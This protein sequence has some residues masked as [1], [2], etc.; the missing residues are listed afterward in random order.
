MRS[1]SIGVPRQRLARVQAALEP[2]HGPGVGEIK[3]FQNFAPCSTCPQDDA[4][5]SS[6]LMPSVAEAIASCN[7]CRYASIDELLGCF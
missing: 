4:R 2:F 1:F 3:V 5:R 7:L 6:A